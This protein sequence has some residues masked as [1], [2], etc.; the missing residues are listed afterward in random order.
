VLEARFLS[1]ASDSTR[2]KLIGKWFGLVAEER[3]GLE[4]LE[5]GRLVYA[6]LTP[7]GTQI[8][9]LTYRVDGD[10]LVTDQPSHPREERTRFGWDDTGVLILEF[11]GVKSR[12]TR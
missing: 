2:A 10:M 5:D 8:M 6:I 12:F 11:G 3:V 4:F 1:G 7:K 9:R